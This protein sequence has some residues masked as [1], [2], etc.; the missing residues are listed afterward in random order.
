MGGAF[1]AVADDATAASWNPGGLTQLEEPELSLV[2]SWKLFEEDF[3]RTNHIRPFDSPMEAGFDDLNYFSLAY[4]IPWTFR[5]RNVVVS[6]NYQ[7]K[8][9]FDRA[10]DFRATDISPGSFIT[11]TSFDIKY[12][13]EGGL[14]TL[15]PGIGFEINEKLSLGLAINLWDSNILSNNRWKTR[16]TY[17]ARTSLIGGSPIFSSG[18]INETF[19]DYEAT[20]YTL[21]LLYKST[22]RLSIGAVYHTKYTAKVKSTKTNVLHWATQPGGSSPFIFISTTRTE[23]EWPEAAALGVAY[24]FPND[25]LTVSADVT[26]RP[27]DDFV[28]RDAAGRRT[29]PITGLRKD[30]SPHDSTYTVRLG[31]EYVSVKEN[32]PKQ[33]YLPSLRAGLFYDP[34]PASGRRHGFFGVTK[35]DGD[36]DDYYGFAL[37]AGVLI[38]NRVNLDVAYQYRWGRDVKADTFAGS[39]P[40][41]NGFSEDVYQ[42]QFYLSTVIY[43]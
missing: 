23:T 39:G 15:S 30:L 13:A 18:E 20:N 5:G 7:R 25:K 2:Y 40:F 41:E 17:K 14:G 8:L 27:W 42:H 26:W 38:K 22:E 24:R 12:R 9:D 32:A 21:G 16:N 43:F 33:D 34:E 19:T 29:S 1:V 28:K 31:T 36:P 10:L 35:G 4:P 11:Q 3:S 6:L 37:G